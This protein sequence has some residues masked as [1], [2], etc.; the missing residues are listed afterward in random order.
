MRNALLVAA[1]L[2]SACAA[3]KNTPLAEI[4]GL[5]T[6]DD[7]M[8]NQATAADPQFKKIGQATFDDAELAALV[9]AAERI[10]ATSLKTKDFSKG[11]K[12]PAAFEALTMKLN[13]QAKALGA[14]A[15]AK[16]AKA[17][18]ATLEEMRG[19]CRECHSKFR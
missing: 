18:S 4:P 10:Q 11:H 8:E 16:D 14:A 13:E 5:K 3:N 15:S 17:I 6:L 1:L 12:D 19:A 2:L 7:V 9:Q